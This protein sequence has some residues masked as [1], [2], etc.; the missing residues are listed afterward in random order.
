MDQSESSFQPQECSSSKALADVLDVLG[1]YM[2]RVT[3]IDVT[4]SRVSIDIAP[5]RHDEKGNTID[6]SAKPE[7]V[8]TLRQHLPGAVFPSRLK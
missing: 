8:E 3:R 7:R 6:S 1:P 5:L 2:A 4:E